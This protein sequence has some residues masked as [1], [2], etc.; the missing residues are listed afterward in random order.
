MLDIIDAVI[1]IV[2][3]LIATV[4]LFLKIRAKKN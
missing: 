2:L 4:D 3:V 1:K